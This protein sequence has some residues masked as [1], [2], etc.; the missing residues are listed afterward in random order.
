MLLA[1]EGLASV[2]IAELA[3]VSLPTVT[4]WRRRYE[5]G[6]VQGLA[7]EAR[8]GRPREIDRK[9]IIAATLAPPPKN[10]GVTHWSS[11]LLAA[12]WGSILPRWPGRGVRPA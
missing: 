7:D 8:S 12:Q 1:S 3:G 4:A 5:A 10:L 6:G 11:R 2:R 9:K